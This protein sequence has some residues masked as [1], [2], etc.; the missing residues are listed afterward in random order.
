MQGVGVY[1]NEATG[2][3]YYMAGLG[4]RGAMTG[5][6]DVIPTRPSQPDPAFGTQPTEGDM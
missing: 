3:S 5:A 2:N 1:T 4:P 6:A